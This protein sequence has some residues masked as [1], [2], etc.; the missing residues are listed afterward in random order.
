MSLTFGGF[1]DTCIVLYRWNP[2]SKDVAV[3]F[4]AELR[5]LAGRSP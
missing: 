1:A 3:R 2:F 5:R 4:E